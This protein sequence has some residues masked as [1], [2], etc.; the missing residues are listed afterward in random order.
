MTNNFAKARRAKNPS[1]QKLGWVQTFPSPSYVT[2]AAS[3]YRLEVE[4]PLAKYT[5]SCL[6]LV[7]FVALCVRGHVDAIEDNA[8]E[9]VKLSAGSQ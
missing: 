7:C 1:C 5:T 6:L 9:R 2:C 4:R 8:H 3:S